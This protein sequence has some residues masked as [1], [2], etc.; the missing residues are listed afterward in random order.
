MP[1][2]VNGCDGMKGAFLLSGM[3]RREAVEL[4]TEWSL[5]RTGH[6]PI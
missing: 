4:M 1:N 6:R 2:L 5:P 3:P